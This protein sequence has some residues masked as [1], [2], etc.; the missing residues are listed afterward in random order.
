MAIPARETGKSNETQVGPEGEV[1]LP[2]EL[3]R[4]LGWQ[5]GDRLWVTVV[6]DD[7]VI[8]MKRPE[9]VADFFAGAFTD[10]YPDPEDT[11]RFLDEGRGYG[12]DP[13]AEP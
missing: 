1:S 2:E 7:Q 12:T 5:P 10:L 6:D 4:E 3:L 13:E 11:R 9:S 8:L